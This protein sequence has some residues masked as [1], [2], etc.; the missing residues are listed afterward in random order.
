M[1]TNEDVHLWGN[2]VSTENSDHKED[3]QKVM[4]KISLG[5]VI[6]TCGL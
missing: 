5:Q 3:W 6:Y 1:S 4:L 2:G